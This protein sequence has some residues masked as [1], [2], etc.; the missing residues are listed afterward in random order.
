NSDYWELT[1]FG[2]NTVDLTGYWFTD[3]KHSLFH[4]VPFGDPPL[5]I[6]PNES[7]IFVR[8]DIT[9]SEALFRAWWGSCVGANVQIR[10]FARPGFSS[11]GDSI[12]I[13]DANREFVDGV[14]FPWATRGRAFVYEPNSGAFGAIS[15][16]GF[17]GGCQAET[18][19][20]IGSPGTTTGPSP[21]RFVR[22]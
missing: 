6:S 10:F 14:A 18:A 22:H 19:E 2:T 11:Y 8:N 7:V 20:D 13:Y 9:T 15:A 5:F 16:V 4:L 17:A 21:L 1:N 3:N 12:L